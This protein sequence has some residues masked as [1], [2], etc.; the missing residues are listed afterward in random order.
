MIIWSTDSNLGSHAEQ[1]VISIQLVTD[2]GITYKLLTGTLPIGLTL[3]SSGLLS[4]TLTTVTMNT[5]YTFVVRAT[6]TT[7]LSDKTFTFV[8]SGEALPIF[9]EDNPMLLTSLDSTW[10]EYQVNVLNKTSDTDVVLVSGSF[11]PGIEINDE[12]IIRGY[13]APP[14]IS[15]KLSEA[16]TSCFSVSNNNINCYSTSGFLPGRIVYFT[17]IPFGGI[18]ENNIYYVKDIIDSSTFTISSTVGGPVINLT[19]SSGIITAILPGITDSFPVSQTYQF[20]LAILNNGIELEPTQF[21][22]TII[23]QTLPAQYGG[24][25]R[26]PNSRPPTM[27]N[28]KPNT[29]NIAKDILNYRY[30]E[31]PDSGITYPYSS[32]IDI[33]RYTSDNFFSFKILG[34][35]FDDNEIE[36]VFSGLPNW[37]TGDETTGWLTGTPSISNPSIE[38]FTITV[39]VRKIRDNSIVSD[40]LQLAFYAVN[41]L[42]GVINWN[43][44]SNLG[45]LNTGS[46]SDLNVSAVSDIPITYSITSGSLPPSLTL[47]PVTGLISGII[48][49]QPLNNN[50]PYGSSTVFTFTVTAESTQYPIIT[51][52][53]VF[54]IVILQKFENPYQTLYCKALPSVADRKLLKS[55]LTDTTLIPDNYLFRPTDENFGKASAIIYPHLYGVDV[56]S[57]TTYLNAISTNHYWR[58]ITLGSLGTA[59]AT[60]QDG[61]IEYEV[62]YAN[63]IDNLVNP[64]GVSI[65]SSVNWPYPIKLTPTETITTVYPNSLYNMRNKIS[66]SITTND[67]SSLLPKWMTSQQKSGST[68]GYTPA[69]VICYTLPGYSSIVK[70]NIET[71]W[72]DVLGNIILLNKINFKIDRFTVDNS[73]TFSYNT[74]NNT[75]EQYPSGIASPTDSQDFS[76]LFPYKT[77]LPK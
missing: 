16:N 61:T 69:W 21:M 68:L 44:N 48:D 72:K 39:F 31:V 23:N 50:L 22:M 8:I 77:I 53:R 41:G 14:T 11:P 65:D 15:A 6:N 3:S 29:Y 12:G 76:V 2:T 35:D 73:I 10:I 25:G 46:K 24:P 56:S 70:N 33:G 17:G 67:D 34:Y 63:V 49:F 43:T 59:I 5:E 64:S 58:N 26:I 36:Y 1:S 55:L 62:V 19:D 52:S 71:N 20:T 74:S 38:E 51:S 4:G 54:T 47:D 9:D 37:L 75:W 45:T 66:E 42:S 7:E 30:Y 32:I 28:I 57:I 60:N 27:F 13:A 40:T 18:V